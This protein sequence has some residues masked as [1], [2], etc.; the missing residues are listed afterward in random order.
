MG[1]DNV[2]SVDNNENKKG[3][4]VLT[5]VL[6]VLAVIIV[7]AVAGFFLSGPILDRFPELKNGFNPNA[8]TQLFYVDGT[9]LAT[10]DGGEDRKPVSINI[11]P[12]DL[13]NAFVATEDVRFY[14][15][16][17]ID[18]I[19]MVRAL[20]VDLK[21]R[22]FVEGGST[23][24]QQLVRNAFL[25]QNQN[26]VRKVEEQFLAVMME[27]RYSKPEILEMYMNQIY[28]GAG[29]Y[30]VESAAETYFNKK[31]SQLSLAE[32]AIIAGVTNNPTAYSPFNNFENAKK[33]QALVLDRMV[34]AGYITETQ[35][36]DAKK[37]PLKLDKDNIKR[38]KTGSYFIDYI[39]QQL[40]D[41]YGAQ[42][43]YRSNMKVYTTLDPDMQLAAEG[44]VSSTLPTY[45]KDENG[46]LQ[47]QAA[48]LALDPQTGY[49]RAMVGGRG[50]DSF[51]RAV[52]AERQPGSA[53]K[54]FVYL[55][56]LESGISPNMQVEDR[57]TKFGDYEPRNYDYQFHG[58]VTV[59][60]ALVNSLNVI[61]TRLCYS[62]G[63][64]KVIDD[65][66]KLGITTLVRDGAANDMNLS[67][68]LGGLTKGATVIDM[69]TAYST[70]ANDGMRMKPIGI[71][72]IE[73]E[74]G[75]VLE[76]Y[77]P[78][79]TQVADAQVVR[80]LDNMMQD[81]IKYG[82]GANAQI[83][84]P[85][86]GKTGTT[87]DWKDAWFIGFTPNLC[88]AVWIGCDVPT[89]MH[90]VTGGDLP[91]VI[92]RKFMLKATAK[93]P[94]E[95]FIAPPAN[96]G[97]S[98]NLKDGVPLTSTVKTQDVTNE[99]LINGP[100]GGKPADA[101]AANAGGA[102]TPANGSAKTATTVNQ[103]AITP[104]PAPAGGQVEKPR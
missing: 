68:A 16:F 61:A 63:P 80:V 31:V 102:T 86:A 54:P 14:K 82:T 50:T 40:V 59:R 52:M 5:I 96:F 56:A 39:V 70:L 46:L 94:V 49:I 78:E 12:K 53:F 77:R 73:D 75:K 42:R 9:V 79:G 24:T 4:S 33:R 37:A 101:N 55:A 87:S 84:R 57:P 3:G 90:G 21:A 76:Q 26:L 17:G 71:L 43:V 81:V 19:S 89:P 83:G 51:N 48:L 93:L 58:V 7:S 47:P 2:R 85:A 65:A 28:F 36:A 45:F 22:A 8:A 29:A 41:Q 13:Q 95:N 35:A 15:H 103:P 38:N 11:V 6:I 69:A 66:E 100:D 62:V 104:Q 74:S 34:E 99:V 97:S 98:Q 64:D 32:C 44:A 23:I 88:A 30:G 60:Q 20:W 92:W 91:A 67:M 10:C 27:R 72:K 1:K 18:P 25:T